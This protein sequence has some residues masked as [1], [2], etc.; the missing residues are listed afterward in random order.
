M[1]HFQPSRSRVAN[2]I[3]HWN[4]LWYI[5]SLGKLV[6]IN[7]SLLSIP[8][9]SYFIPNSILDLISKLPNTFLRAKHGNYNGI[10]LVS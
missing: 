4:M 10:R 1:A 5:F 3:A 8:Q 7:C 2:S 9:P 6:L